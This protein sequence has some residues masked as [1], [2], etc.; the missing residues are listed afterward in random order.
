MVQIPAHS[1]VSY[2]RHDERPGRSFAYVM[3][4]WPEGDVRTDQDGVL[5]PGEFEPAPLPATFTRRAVQLRARRLAA[6][7]Q[8][9]CARGR[10]VGTP[11][12][13]ELRFPMQLRALARREAQREAQGLNFD[14]L[15]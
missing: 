8:Q 14:W 5:G 11:T 1:I 2:P 6:L 15:T 3:V 7:Y 12:W 9:R 10:F 4:S 13:S